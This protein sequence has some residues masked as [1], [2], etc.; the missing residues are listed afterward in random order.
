MIVITVDSLGHGRFKA[1]SGERVLVTSSRQPFLAAARILKGYGMAEDTP[2]AMRH[3][4]Q[5]YD[6]LRSTVGKAARL[7][8][9]DR[10]GWPHFKAFTLPD[11]FALDKVSRGSG[12]QTPED[13]GE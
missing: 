10:G 6:A 12:H 4:G 5:D 1:S 7:T 3:R 8:V 11:V 2:I 13:A 9:D